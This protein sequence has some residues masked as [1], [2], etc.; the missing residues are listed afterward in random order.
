MFSHIFIPKPISILQLFLSFT[1]Q[2]SISFF[3]LVY[4]NTF[5]TKVIHIQ[6]TIPQTVGSKN[7]KIAHFQ[8]PVSFFIVRSV[9]LQGKCNNVKII[10]LIAVSKVQPFSTNIF[11]IR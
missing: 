1:V 3:S 10:T 5:H 6:I 7:D 2:K 4:T 8:L 9:V 11:P